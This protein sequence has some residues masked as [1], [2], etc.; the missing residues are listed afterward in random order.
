MLFSLEKEGF[1]SHAARMNPED[2]RVCEVIQSS[3]DKC[4]MI[5]LV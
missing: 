3:K 1:L 4:H 2:G 5:L